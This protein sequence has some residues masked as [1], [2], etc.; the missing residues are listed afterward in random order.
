MISDENLKTMTN[1]PPALVAGKVLN[2]LAAELL[3]YREAEYRAPETLATYEIDQLANGRPPTEYEPAVIAMAK[4]IL[5]WRRWYGVRT[6]K[7][8]KAEQL[9]YRIMR[10]EAEMTPAPWYAGGGE[11]DCRAWTGPV[12][13]HGYPDRLIG[14]HEVS[15]SSVSPNPKPNG[16]G[17]A[18]IR[19]SV[20]ELC[21]AVFTAASEVR[22]LKRQVADRWQTDAPDQSGRY[23]V[24]FG[25]QMV[26][27]EVEVKE[28]NIFWKWVSGA[29][30]TPRGEGLN[31]MSAYLRIPETR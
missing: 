15:D 5:T 2:E 11:D 9:A 31:G 21:S 25:A 10:I 22:D 23:V 26:V 7:I 8:S 6:V 27:V 14:S 18:A 29:A 1:D 20:K 19:N 28:H 24:L 12:D 30:S 17:I 4:E 13:E 16:R 3:A